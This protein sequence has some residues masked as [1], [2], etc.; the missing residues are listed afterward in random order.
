MPMDKSRYPPN[1]SEIARQVKEQAGWK[2]EHCG[3]KHGQLIVRS[4]KEPTRYLILD[5]EELTYRDPVDGSLMVD[6]ALIE[7]TL[8]REPIRIVL[9]V[10]HIGIPKSDGSPGDPNDKMDCRRENLIALCQKCHFDADR[11]NNLILSHQSRIA[12]KVEAARSA[13]QMEMFE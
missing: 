2:C 13:G 9:T 6:V 4:A 3:V 11:A 7:E 5:E 8:D 12:K 1:W 10:H